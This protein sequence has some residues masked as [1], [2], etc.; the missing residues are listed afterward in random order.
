MDWHA[1][2]RSASAERTGSSGGVTVVVNTYNHAH[3]LADALQSIV[4]QTAPASAVIVVDDG[5]DDHPEL[6]VAEFPQVRIIRQVNQGLAAARNTGLEAADTEFICFLDADDRLLPGALEAGLG[7]LQ[8]N[9]DAAF[10]YGGFRRIDAAGKPISPDLY[11]PPGDL[12]YQTLLRGNPIAMHATVLYRTQVLRASGGYDSGLRLCEDYDVY[13]KLAQLHPIASYPDPVAEYRF[14][15]GN[16]SGDARRML[17]ATLRV[18]E[19]HAGEAGAAEGAAAW[20]RYY[21]GIALKHA[22]EPERSVAERLAKL[23]DSIAISPANALRRGLKAVLPAGVVK[24][25][26]RLVRGGRPLGTVRLGDL[27]Q[28]VP[29]HADFGWGRG[30]PVDRHYIESFLERRRGDIHGRVLEIG[31]DVYSKRYGGANVTRQDILHVHAGNPRATLIG[32]VS[33]ASTLPPGSFDCI[34]FT[35]TLQLIFDLDAAVRNLHAALAPGGVLLVTVPGISQI[36]RGEWGRDW[37]WMMTPAAVTRLFG[38]VFGEDRIEVQAHGNVYAAT[39]YLQGM[40]VE[41]LDAA[42]LDVDDAAYPVI[43]AV[44]ARKQ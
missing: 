12:P 37:F 26:R 14:H 28:T 31:D 17:K 3:F 24:R 41:E 19:R 27:D 18:L 6:V 33:A 23:R 11:S 25:A 7:A 42:K 22:A 34:V 40:V 35:Q 36:D 29:V 9:L 39:T 1:D 13:L 2:Q 38:P 32:D 8:Q 43:V 16:M 5:S 30:T 4:A 20:K 21:S 10:A 15:G 44:R